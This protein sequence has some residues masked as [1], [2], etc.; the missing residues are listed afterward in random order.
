[1]CV[2]LFWPK[3][4]RWHGHVATV[5]ACAAWSHSLT[6]LLRSPPALRA[7][8]ARAGVCTSDSIPPPPAPRRCTYGR[9]G[10]QRKVEPGCSCWNGCACGSTPTCTRELLPGVP[11][12]SIYSIRVLVTRACRPILFMRGMS[13]ASSPAPCAALCRWCGYRGPTAAE[14]RTGA[15]LAA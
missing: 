11:S 10:K 13:Q 5:L 3:T 6:E 14:V 7:F 2:F 15:S 12:Q 1:L 8:C 4:S 9:Q